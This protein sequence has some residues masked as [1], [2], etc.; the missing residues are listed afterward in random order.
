MNFNI[1]PPPPFQRKIW[2]YARADVR[3]I[4]RAISDYPWRLRLNSNPDP[5]WQVTLFTETILNI[6][7]NFIPNE[8]IKVTPKDPPWITKPLKTL[9]NRQCRLYKNYKT[10]GYQPEDKIRVDN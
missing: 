3:L 10:H 8:I 2:K 6:M 1:P 9:L 7:S 4:K 5:N